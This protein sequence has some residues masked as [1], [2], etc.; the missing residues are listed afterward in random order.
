MKMLGP[1]ATPL[2]MSPV[3]SGPNECVCPSPRLDFRSPSSQE[4]GSVH[5]ALALGPV[6]PSN[7]KRSFSPQRPS[8]VSQANG[9]LAVGL[10]GSSTTCGTTRNDGPELSSQP[11]PE[12]CSPQPR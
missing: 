8:N 7:G 6:G 9:P 10:S 3:G 11:R 1:K 4:K 12:P 5:C 2:Q